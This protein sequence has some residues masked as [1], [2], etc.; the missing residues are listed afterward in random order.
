M[1]Q[2]MG[3]QG[4][5]VGLIV[6]LLALAIVAWLAKD[7][8][9]QYGLLSGPG[10]AAEPTG[11][12]RSPTPAAV[13]DTR[14]GATL[15][16]A[17][18]SAARLEGAGARSGARCARQAETQLDSASIATP[19][20]TRHHVESAA[21]RRPSQRLLESPSPCRTIRTRSSPAKAGCSSRSPLSSRC[22]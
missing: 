21:Q 16:P 8:L 5:W 20:V 14:G 9:K 1:H 6:V 7:A 4:G 3:K 2:R 22:C 12:Q 17:P 10:K 13:S 15:V 18:S 19:T 11:L